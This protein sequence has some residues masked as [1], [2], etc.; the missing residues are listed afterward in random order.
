MVTLSPYKQTVIPITVRSQSGITEITYLYINKISTVVDLDVTLDDKEPDGYD[1]LTHTFTFLIDDTKEDFELFT[2]AD[3]EYTLLEYEE[4]QYQGSFKNI[5]HVEKEIEGKSFKIIATSEA[6]ITQEY[7]VDVVHKSDNTNLDFLKVNDIL[8]QPDEPGGDTYTVIISKLAETTL[9]EIQTEH[10]FAQLRLGDNNTVKHY[11]KATLDCN[12]LKLDRIVVP[13]VVTAP[14]GETVRT[15]NVILIR[16]D[17]N[18]DIKLT[19]NNEILMRD[20]EGN[21]EINLPETIENI[22]ILAEALGE[23]GKTT[24]DINETGNP[25]TPTKEI[26]LEK[27]YW[28]GKE[29][30][31]I[32]IKVIAEDGTIK[33]STLTINIREG[34]Y[35]SG[36]ITTENVNG[37]HLA[38]VTV[39]RLIENI[40]ESTGEIIVE[41]EEVVKLN[42]NLDGTFKALVYM[43]GKDDKEKLKDKYEVV[44][45]K[46][47]YLDYTVTKIEIEEKKETELDEYK[48]IAGD[49]VKTGEIEIDD[50]VSL[51]EKIGV[52]ITN[53]NKEENSIYDLNEDGKIDNLDKNIL[54]KNYTKKAKIV[55][56]V[57]PNGVTTISLRNVEQEE[58]GFI[59]PITCDYK[60]TSDYGVRIHPITG[61]EK[62]HT[63]IDIGGEHHTE[64]LSVADGEVTFSG[65]Q[66]AYGNCIEVKHIVNGETIYTFYAHLSE[67]KVEVGDKVAQGQVIGLEGG[68]P[69]SDPNP[70]M[71]TGHHLHFGIRKLDSTNTKIDVN[72][73]LYIKF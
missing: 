34:T 37:E 40:E 38:D 66:N 73:N 16:G 57:N 46:K 51:N 36:K 15:Y 60:I 41:R 56:W 59:L 8:R 69:E 4:T 45:S 1:E 61:V 27:E 13:I 5:V 14:D 72:P 19:V 9:F 54:K 50:L 47:G 17:N 23:E 70:G 21:Y 18:T 12:D 49:I 30:I 39:Y 28:E 44:I 33:N 43:T 2:I 26:T 64:I 42:T 53:E 48:L 11:D 67:R 22:R 35:I 3:S 55:Q 31:K 29:S 6:G 32:P 63:G 20:D 52:S 7:T 25:E 58:N 24:I 62:K 71:S 68:N 65:V 10:N